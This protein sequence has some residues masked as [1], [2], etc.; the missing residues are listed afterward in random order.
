MKKQTIDLKRIFY[1]V[2]IGAIVILGITIKFAFGATNVLPFAQ[3]G[4]NDSSALYYDYYPFYRYFF[5]SYY[6]Q[7]DYSNFQ[8]S[9]DLR[10]VTIAVN[11]LTDNLNQFE[12]SGYYNLTGIAGGSGSGSFPNVI[13]STADIPKNSSLISYV[14]FDLGTTYHFSNGGFD[15]LIGNYHSVGSGLKASFDLVGNISATNNFQSIEY[16]LSNGVGVYALPLDA[17]NKPFFYFSDIELSLPPNV[18]NLDITIDSNFTAKISGTTTDSVGY[19]GLA[20]DIYDLNDNILSPNNSFVALNELV[21]DADFI[22]HLSDLSAGSYRARFR[23]LTSNIM[24]QSTAVTFYDF[25]L[26]EPIP[27]FIV[28]PD[29]TVT[30]TAPNYSLTNP[31]EFYLA[32]S[33]YTNSTALYSNITTAIFPVLSSANNWSSSFSE[34]FDSD[35]A[36]NSGTLIGDGVSNVISY[37]NSLNGFF[38]NLP[39]TQTLFIFIIINLALAVLSSIRFIVKLVK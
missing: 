20:V 17:N 24:I 22:L 2:L 10:Y 26:A 33:N 25:V 3:L 19:L 4:T 31:D 1:T 11:N 34:R 30:P 7:G 39:I 18:K 9:G 37:S 15:I 38:G 13:V 28:N 29:N 23:F 32:N 14:T 36:V 16:R 6:G 5:G 21:T 12:L 8:V 35:E 27:P